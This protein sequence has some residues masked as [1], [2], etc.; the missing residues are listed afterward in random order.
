MDRTPAI[1]E[2]VAL[3]TAEIALMRSCRPA[4]LSE[5]DKDRACFLAFRRPDVH[6]AVEDCPAPCEAALARFALGT[7]AGKDNIR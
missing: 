2:V 4:S 1:P 6:D 5:A 7:Y 3:P